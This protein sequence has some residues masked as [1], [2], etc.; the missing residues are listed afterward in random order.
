MRQFPQEALA[1]NMLAQGGLTPHHVDLLAET[2]ADFHASAPRASG[3]PAWG[4]PAAV[5]ESA[6]QNF[7]VLMPCLEHGAERNALRLLR[8]WT[9]A[10]YST[11]KN[12]FAE[13]RRQG[14]VRECHGDLHLGNIAVLDGRPVAFD[15][16]EFNDRFRWI[17][18]MSEVAFVVMDIEDRGSR[19]LAWRFLNR[20]LEA[21]GDYPGVD[22]LRFYLV[23]RALVRA[24]VHALRARQLDIEHTERQR[25][26]QIVRDYLDLATKFTE[27]RSAAI[28]ITHGVSGSGKTSAT[29]SL[30]ECIGA[31]RVRSD[32]ERKRLHGLAA[33]ARSDS[34]PDAG[35]Y[36]KEAT[37]A[38][39]DRLRL[40]ARGIA[41]AGYRVAVDATFLKK[42]ERDRF[43]DLASALRLPFLILALDAPEETLRE[44][45]AQRFGRGSDASEANLT[46][47]ARQLA[48]RERITPDEA[49]AIIIDTRQ[50]LPAAVWEPVLQRLAP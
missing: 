48:T 35:I 30:L 13:R 46:V 34:R 38:T 8:S 28:I 19:E 50:P 43:R 42:S 3:A 9:T 37:A 10:E 18:V 41:A 47:L 2:I 21:T 49:S 22:V 29:Q 32:I 25:L 7:E 1:S 14:Y 12:A 40:L 16:I 26:R 5:L 31:V 39:Y 27:S 15:C 20:Y 11:R 33:L 45:V 23:Y 6:L 24:K 17:D 44:R 36:A 4:T